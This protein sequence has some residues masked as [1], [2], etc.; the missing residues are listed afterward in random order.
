MEAS[1]GEIVQKRRVII[2]EESIEHRPAPTPSE[3]AVKA[4]RGE[5][6]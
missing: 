2:E 4:D 5:A 3:E 6:E 1:E